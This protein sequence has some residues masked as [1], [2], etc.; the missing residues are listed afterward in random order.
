[1]MMV[2]HS[3]LGTFPPKL[4]VGGGGGSR[5]RTHTHPLRHTKYCAASFW[6]AAFPSPHAQRS[7]PVGQR[8]DH[9][10]IPN[11]QM[12]LAYS[13]VIKDGGVH[14]EAPVYRGEDKQHTH[15][16]NNTLLVVV[17]RGILS[18]I[19]SNEKCKRIVPALDGEIAAGSGCGRS[20]LA[21]RKSY[22]CFFPFPKDQ[23]QELEMIHPL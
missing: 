9:L 3:N 16:R 19:M 7:H 1:M 4:A 6:D 15:Y 14:H 10:Q 13:N 23:I 21:N 18:L 17:H 8:Q 5:R 22:P 2:T 12:T 11:F 20:L